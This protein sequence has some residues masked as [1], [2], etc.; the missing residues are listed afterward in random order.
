MSPSGS[1]GISCQL[2]HQLKKRWRLPHE[3]SHRGQEI[4]YAGGNPP[5]F[6]RT[7]DRTRRK[8]SA[9]KWTRLRHDQVGLKILATKGWRIQ[10]W[11]R[12]RYSGYR[13]DCSQR[14]RIPRL[15]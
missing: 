5:C 3:E 7:N 12:H 8:F 11:K 14:R 10:V 9:E 15:V 6:R 13:I 4:N 2:A 1:I